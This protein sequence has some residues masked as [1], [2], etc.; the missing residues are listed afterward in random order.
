M[1]SCREETEL[2]SQRLDRPLSFGEHFGLCFHLL[3]CRGCRATQKH[4][5]FLHTAT[6]AWR[7]HHDVDSTPR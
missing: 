7:E 4:F 3:F 2:I 1:R 5:A 6:R